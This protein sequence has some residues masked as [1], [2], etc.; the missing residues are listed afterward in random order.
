VVGNNFRTTRSTTAS[1]TPA[2]GSS[3]HRA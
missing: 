1:K 3:W 2:G